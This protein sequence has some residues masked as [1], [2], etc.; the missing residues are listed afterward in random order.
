MPVALASDSARSILGMVVSKA[1]DV[2]AR[3]AFLSNVRREMGDIRGSNSDSAAILPARWRRWVGCSGANNPAESGLRLLT[4]AIDGWPVTKA[5]VNGEIDGLSCSFHF[6]KRVA[7]I[8]I[9]NAHE[10]VGRLRFLG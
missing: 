8:N 6:D 10:I 3:G 1:M 9:G 7:K 2:A 5:L 4:G